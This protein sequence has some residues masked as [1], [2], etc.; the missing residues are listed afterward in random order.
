MIRSLLPLVLLTL[1]A[2][3][4]FC[5]YFALLLFCDVVRPAHP[6]YKADATQDGAV[7]ITG[8]APDSPVARAGM[9]VGDRLSPSMAWP[10]STMAHGA[11]SP[12]FSRSVSRCGWSS[13]A[14]GS[15]WS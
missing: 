5:L 8:I 13:N 2:A 10:S 4:S 12:W 3:G 1:V 15:R 11:P 7:V 14:T 6:G 9:A